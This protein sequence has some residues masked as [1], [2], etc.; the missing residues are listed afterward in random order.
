MEP[1]SSREA[2]NCAATQELLSILWNPKVYYC[3]H[4]SPP[5]WARSIQS[6]SPDPIS[7]RSILIL[8]KSVFWVVAPCRYSVNRRFGVTY[9]RHL[10]VEDKKKS[11]ETSFNTISTRRHIPEDWFHHS[12]NRE[13]LKSYIL[14]L[15]TQLRLRLSSGL[16]LSGFPTNITYAFLFPL[17]ISPSLIWSL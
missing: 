6:I 5:F 13:N 4:K 12:H 14:I 11:S 17:P 8:M 2:T 1:S 9:R 16:F 15:F 7:P 3:V 10:Q